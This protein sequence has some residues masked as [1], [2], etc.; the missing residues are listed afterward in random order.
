[1]PT[2]RNQMR[3]QCKLNVAEWVNQLGSCE[4]EGGVEGQRPYLGPSTVRSYL[5]NKFATVSKNLFSMNQP[6]NLLHTLQ[7]LAVIR[8]FSLT[9]NHCIS[10]LYFF[11]GL[12]FP[13]FGVNT[14]RYRVS[15]QSI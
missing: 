11:S 12:Y 2:F 1:M 8:Y 14:E 15:S 4:D 9:D 10:V 5:E 7:L 13:A 6:I 3:V